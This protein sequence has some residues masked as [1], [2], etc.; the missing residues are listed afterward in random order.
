MLPSRRFSRSR[1]GQGIEPASGNEQCPTWYAAV[2][3]EAGGTYGP[4]EAAG[5][6]EDQVKAMFASGTTASPRLCGRMTGF[7]PLRPFPE[8]IV[9]GSFGMMTG[10]GHSSPA[11]AGEHS[12]R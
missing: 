10:R 1:H 8:A 5:G 3:A 12:R 9:K 11:M 2:P 7:H 6:V 4:V